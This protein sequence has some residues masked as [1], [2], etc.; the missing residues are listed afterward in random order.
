MTT[1]AVACSPGEKSAADKLDKAFDRLGE[2]KAVS[3]EVAL[4]ASADEIHTALKDS[5]DGLDREDAEVL[6]GLKL[7]YGISSSKPL[8]TED[9]KNADVNVSF[10]LS[11][12][13]GG[14]LLEFRSLDKKAYVRADI[15][16]IGGMKK[17]GNAKERAEKRDFDEMLRRADELPPS[18]GAFRDVLKGEWVSM[19][20]ADFEE[21]RKKA[22]EKNGGSPK[23]LDK[24]TE[25][26]ASDALR[27]ALTENSR[28]KETGSKNGADHIEVTVSARKAA[29][30]LKEA[31]K[32]IESQLSAAGKGRKL[33]DPNDVPDQDVVFDVA[34]KGG[35]LSAITFDTGRLDKDVHGKL[36]VTIGFGGK[37]EPVT[38]PSG[39]KELKPQEMLEAI[40]GLAAE[41]DNSRSL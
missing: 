19:N 12:K 30:D 24:K 8:K 17:P 29:K 6:A 2:G 22:Q 18:M 36:P 37:P 33:P 38:A 1:G 14:E 15:K 28:I 21:F 34:L 35:R 9:K 40:V 31:L 16:A 4:D 13:S 25:K 23:E 32:P 10:K 5:E 20:S 26:Q 3:L 39:A 11:K 27:K 7:S 41:K